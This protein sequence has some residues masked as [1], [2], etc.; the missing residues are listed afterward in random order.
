MSRDIFFRIIVPIYN[1]AKYLPL[2]IDSILQQAN[3]SMELIL[4]DDGS[5][6]ESIS[7][8][9][10]YSLNQFVKVIHKHNGGLS[11]ARNAGIKV[12]KGKY[13]LFVDGDDYINN[14][15]LQII[16]DDCIKQNFPDVVLLQAY[17]F[18]ANGKIEKLDTLPLLKNIRQ[19]SKQECL[20]TIASMDKYPGSACT[21]L[22]SRSLIIANNLFFEIGVKSEDL[23]WSQK[24]FFAAETFGCIDTPYYN[25]RKGRQ[26]SITTTASYS[27]FVDV[28]NVIERW[29]IEAEKAV[30]W[31]QKVLL[32]FSAYEYKVLLALYTAID[33][34]DKDV[35]FDWLKK[36]Q[37]L[38][39]YR[40]DRHFKIIKISKSIIGLSATLKLIKIRYL[41]RNC[42]LNK[43]NS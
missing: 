5:T 32:R 2:C 9:D 8:C 10:S 27:N 24:L 20:E 38:M 1:V 34:E 23:E 16:K 12:A 29:L 22:I 6:D 43:I 39:K 11:D 3:D 13:I 41:F 21:K 40:D 18:Y 4:V 36:H 15:S 42:I 14:G 37:Y 19:K 26:G 7:I 17:S 33:D 25:Y 30:K 28:T 35:A 31:K